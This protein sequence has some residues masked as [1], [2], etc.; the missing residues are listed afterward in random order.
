MIT[1]FFLYGTA[2]KE[3]ATAGLVEEA[4]AA[5][6]RGIDTACQRKHYNEA[7][8][9]EGLARSYERGLAARDDLF[10]QTKF[11]YL[12]GQDERVPYD[13]RAPFS[14][15]VR[16]S[17]AKSLENL[18]TDRVD[19]Y[20]LHGPSQRSGLGDPDFEVWME[21]EALHDEGSVEHLGVSNVNIGQLSALWDYA[22]IKP[23]FVQ[24][25]CFAKS[26]WDREIRIF[27]RDRGIVYQGFSLLTANRQE[28]SVP[29]VSA[30]AEAK[31]ATVPQLVFAFALQVGMLP[32]TGTTAPDHMRQDLAS[33][34]FELTPEEIAFME[35]V[36]I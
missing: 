19:S 33:E 16:Q 32:L 27:C 9:G 21:M 12:A 6:F 24:N 5:G 31:E 22:K 3:E 34:G 20:V 11:T 1:P 10:L 29:R 23:S 26:G 30:M 14:D 25:R 36:G 13:P 35:S 28:L 8:V 18:R 15:Q 17:F 2:W 7:G 4:V